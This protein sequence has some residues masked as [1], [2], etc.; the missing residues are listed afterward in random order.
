MGESRPEPNSLESLVGDLLAAANPERDAAWVHEHAG[1]LAASALDAADEAGAPEPP[2]APPF[3]RALREAL[4]E[5]RLS[6]ETP[7]AH[8]LTGD[9]D[10]ALVAAR[11]APDGRYAIELTAA[12]LDSEVVVPA[13]IWLVLR[14]DGGTRALRHLAGLDEAGRAEFT[15]VPEGDWAF[16][17]L[18][19]SGTARDDAIPLPVVRAAPGAIAA[20][21]GA[22]AVAL[23]GGIVLLLSEPKG[24]APYVLEVLAPGGRMKVFQVH[25]WGTDGRPHTLFVPGAHR[26]RLRMRDFAPSGPWWLADATGEIGPADTERVQASVEAADNRVTTLAWRALLG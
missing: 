15:G 4:A 7:R 23:P 17:L 19:L 12:H 6:A 1:P 9:L 21:G 18:V 13:G 25:Y 22:Y 11:T 3:D 20:A 5:V 16:D 10:L 14:A 8:V 24:T 26:S 2:A